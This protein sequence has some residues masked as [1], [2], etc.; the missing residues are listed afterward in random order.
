MNEIDLDSLRDIVKASQEEELSKSERTKLLEEDPKRYRPKKINPKF[1][2]EWNSLETDLKINRLIE[3]VGRYSAEH[4][5]PTSTSKKIR[6]LLVTALVKGP[7]LEVEYDQ[8][9]GVIKNIPKLFFNHKD[10][11]FLGTYL[12]NE[13]EL[14]TKVS[15]IKNVDGD[16][17]ITT[18][19]YKINLRLTRK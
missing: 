17:T 7:S 19:D 4:D 15:R 8:A 11:Y 3:Y 5:L 18:E 16:G 2:Y 1:C 12:N 10:G 14:T 6:R 13:G 9:M